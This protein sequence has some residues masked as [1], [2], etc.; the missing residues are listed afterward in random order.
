MGKAV[1]LYRCVYPAFNCWEAV[2]PKAVAAVV[3][4]SSR[5]VAT[6]LHLRQWNLRSAVMWPMIYRFNK[7]K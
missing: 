2:Q 7:L 6:V 4:T 1:R 5:V 3:V